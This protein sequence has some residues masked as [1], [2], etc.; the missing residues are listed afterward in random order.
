MAGVTSVLDIAKG[1]LL[2]HQLSVQVA[3]NNIANVDTPGYSRQVLT[4]ANKQATP[5]SIGSIGTGVEAASIVRQYDQILAS[6]VIEQNTTLANFEAQEKTLSIVETIFN[7][8]SGLGLNDLMAQYW[9]SWQDVA[10]LPENLAARQALLQSGFLVQDYLGNAYSEIVKARSDIANELNTAISEVNRLTSQLADLNREISTLEKPGQQ[11]NG[12]RDTRDVLLGQLSSFIDISTYENPSNGSVSALLADGHALVDGTESNN[13][14]INGNELVWISELPDGREIRAGLGEGEE[15]GGRIGGWLEVHNEL[16]PGDPDN[17]FGRLGSFTNSLIREVNQV[18]SQGVGMVRFS[19]N[20][21][22]TERAENTAIL[23]TTVDATFANNDIA[24]GIFEIN[25]RDV[26]TI[27]GGAAVDGLAMEKAYNAVNAINNAQENVLARLTTQVAGGTV[28]GLAAA[29]DFVDFAV[30]GIAVTYTAAGAELPGA[31]ALGV[32][33]AINAAIA[34]YNA[35]PTTVPDEMTIEAVVGDGTNGGTIDSIIFRNTMAGE[36]SSIIISGVDPLTNPEDANLSFVDGTYMADAT[37]NTGEITLFSNE[38]FEVS[39]GPNDNNLAHL[40][41]GGGL[42]IDD[43]P[44]DG[45]FI[46]GFDNPGGVQA[47]LMGFEYADEVVTDGGSFEIWLYDAN[48]IPLL[49][50]GVNVQLDRAYTLQDV[51]QAV[52]TSVTNATGGPA[53]LTAVVTENKLEF[54]PAADVQ[55]AFANDNSNILQAAGINTFFSGNDAST[56]RVNSVLEQ[57][58]SLVAVGLVDDDGA[59]FRGDNE[60]ALALGLVQF[61]ESVEF[62]NG[63]VTTLDG[64]YNALV[65][66]LGSRVR[67]VERNA[68]LHTMISNQLNDLR[69][70]FAG[71]SLDEELANLIKFQQAYTAAAKLVSTSDEM[72]ETLV[73]ILRR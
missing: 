40:G 66:D 53:Y 19:D 61:D 46:Y 36:D 23:T 54:M 52:N 69:D 42:H 16:V 64:F 27:N 57:D 22:G 60:N 44:N 62:S 31:T 43:F 7:E 30:N 59:V 47:A 28:V 50:Y 5:V 68:E 38:D 33:G 35:D 2:T 6:R 20:L 9:Q 39:A 17:V 32:V 18:H 29:G 37:H 72:L 56:I 70:S 3:S 65:G 71:V 13:I 51:A 73:N 55:F 24:A 4:L 49:P 1:A 58:V 34:A 41:M 67:M 8:A 11:V 21:I 63:N 10:N 25:G 26:G 48:D 45:S 12:L 14:D 15:L